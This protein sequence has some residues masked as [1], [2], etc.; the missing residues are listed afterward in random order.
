MLRE[1]GP[2]VTNTPIFNE[3]MDNSG[4]NHISFPIIYN[5]YIEPQFIHFDVELP[6]PL[7][8]LGLVVNNPPPNPLIN[9]KTFVHKLV[10]F[11]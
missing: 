1:T 5:G 10:K 3:M 8:E 6:Q 2:I 7:E 4:F 9:F 11:L